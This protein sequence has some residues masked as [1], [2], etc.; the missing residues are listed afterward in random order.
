MAFESFQKDFYREFNEIVQLIDEIASKVDSSS[1]NETERRLQF[2]AEYEKISKRIDTLQK[3]FGENT[4]YLPTFEVRKAQEHLSKLNKLMQE[5]RELLAPKKKFGF[6]SKQNLTSLEK[7][8]ETESAAAVVAATTASNK[9]S[10]NQVEMN[11]ESSCGIKG[12]RDQT[13][14]KFGAEIDGKDVSIIDV[15]NSTICLQGK[16]TTSSDY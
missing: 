7:K 4:A 11:V 3:F 16:N 13:V 14:V 12:L 2:T 15:K 5:K 9:S 10:S 1:G 6:R 8:I